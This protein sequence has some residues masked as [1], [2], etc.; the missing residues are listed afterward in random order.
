MYDRL[1][2]RNVRISKRELEQIRR[3]KK[4]AFFGERSLL[5]NELNMTSVVCTSDDV[6][7]AEMLWRGVLMPQ[8]E[9]D[10]RQAFQQWHTLRTGERSDGHAIGSPTRT[11]NRPGDK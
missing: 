7:V 4:G 3:L 10:F 9:E 6:T 5:K 11:R 2:G 1:N 8:S